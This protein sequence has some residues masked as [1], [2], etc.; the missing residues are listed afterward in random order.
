MDC[1]DSLLII[2]RTLQVL[3]HSSQKTAHCTILVVYLAKA[4]VSL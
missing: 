2:N 3:L 1:L 4:V